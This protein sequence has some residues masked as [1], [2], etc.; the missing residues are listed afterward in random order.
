MGKSDRSPDEASRMG[1]LRKTKNRDKR[2]SDSRVTQK[3]MG[4]KGRNRTES[5]CWAA[6]PPFLPTVKREHCL[7]TSVNALTTPK[8]VVIMTVV[9]IIT[10]GTRRQFV[11][12]WCSAVVSVTVTQPRAETTSA[13]LYVVQLSTQYVVLVVTPRVCLEDGKGKRGNTYISRGC[14]GDNVRSFDLF[15]LLEE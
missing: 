7:H 14:A 10:R 1:R 5:V 4:A 13:S 12:S 6:S 11:Q 15:F 8:V 2:H 9:V 3:V